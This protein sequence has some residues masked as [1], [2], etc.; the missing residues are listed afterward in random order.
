MFVYFWHYSMQRKRRMLCLVVRG[1][2]KKATTLSETKQLNSGRYTR[3][4]R[5]FTELLRRVP[6]P[7]KHDN[8]MAALVFARPAELRRVIAEAYTR[9]GSAFCVSERVH[10]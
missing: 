9:N 6:M 4:T 5:S 10:T 1:C 3:L 7:A 2:R 8:L